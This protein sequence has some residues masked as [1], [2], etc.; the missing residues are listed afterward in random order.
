[1][2]ETYLQQ[3]NESQIVKGAKTGELEGAEKATIKPLKVSGIEAPEEAP[4]ELQGVSEENQKEERK[5]ITYM[6]KDDAFEKLYRQAINEDFSTG[7]DLGGMD[8]IGGGDVGGGMDD[9]DQGD[10]GHGGDIDADPSH[11]GK[12]KEV[13]DLLQQALD[14]LS[15]FEGEEEEE[16]DE[17]EGEEQGGDDLLGGGDDMGEEPVTKEEVEAEYHGHALADGREGL[18][19]GMNKP[20]NMVVKGAVPNAGKKV[21]TSSGKKVDGKLSGFSDAGS[22][23]MQGKGNMKVSDA[24]RQNTPGKFAFED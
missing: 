15:S 2:I 17:Y 10:E 24:R 22:K 7:E 16:Y 11:I 20:G 1:M 21:T 19:K 3:L 14:T 12:V 5:K 18:M 23:K 6:S 8:E 4:E 9:L 13:I